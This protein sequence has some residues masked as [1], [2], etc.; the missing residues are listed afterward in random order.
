ML[1][2]RSFLSFSAA[3]AAEL[4]C[5]AA[6][7][8][9]AVQVQPDP[10]GLQ[11]LF[12]SAPEFDAQFEVYGDCPVQAFGTVLDRDLYFRARNEGWSFDVADYAGNLP[13]DGYH[14]SDGFYREDRY[15]R[16]S[17]MPLRDAVKI[18][19]RCLEEYTGVRA[20]R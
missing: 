19:I 11:R 10:N 15:P 12:V 18:I 8:S 1:V 6:W 14:D 16:A 17:W 5:S 9:L 7:E 3:A 13:S 4:G 2:L 20:Q